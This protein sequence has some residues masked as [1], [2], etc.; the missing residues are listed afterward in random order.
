MLPHT[1]EELDEIR[2]FCR[3]LVRKRATIV[4]G[5]AMIPIPGLD[6]L[7]DVGAL[8]KLIPKINQLFGLT[9]QQIEKLDERRQSTIHETVKKV[10]ADF[11][12]KSITR[13]LILSVLKR[14]GMRMATKRFLR[15]VPVAGQAA[16]AAL[17]YGTMVYVS[18]AHIDACY[19]IAKAAIKGSKEEG[20]RR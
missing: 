17:S 2:A 5:L 19:D 20:H 12:G 14:A 18:N 1:I 15:Y 10:G 11:V 7:V 9:P 16:A 6:L 13:R 3:S 4:G 8:S